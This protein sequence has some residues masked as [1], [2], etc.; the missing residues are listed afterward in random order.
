[1]EVPVKALSAYLCVLFL[2]AGCATN[3][4]LSFQLLDPASK[5]QRGSLFP[6]TER[7]EVTV[8][9]A[10]YSGFYITAGGSVVSHATLGRRFFPSETVSTFSSNS[11]RAHLT[12]ENGMHLTCDFLLETKRAVG[13]CRSSSGAVY[14]LVADGS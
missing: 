7:I 3:Q 12:A 11:A 6:D 2:T 5:V 14:Q 10:L 8:D 1:M 9:G 4:P 13:E